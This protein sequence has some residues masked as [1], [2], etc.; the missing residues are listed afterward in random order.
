[1][2][3]ERSPQ[4]SDDIPFRVNWPGTEFSLVSAF[5][6]PVAVSLPPGTKGSAPSLGILRFPTPR[7]PPRTTS[8]GACLLPHS[9]TSFTLRSFI[10]TASVYRTQYVDVSSMLSIEDPAVTCSPTPF[11][12]VS[13][14]LLTN[15]LPVE[16][17][18]LEPRQVYSFYVLFGKSIAA[19][20]PPAAFS[21]SVLHTALPTHTHTQCVCVG[22]A[23]VSS[24]CHHIRSVSLAHYTYIYAQLFSLRSCF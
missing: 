12:N 22:R 6:N 18:S 21:P 7:P 19:L 8:A 10:H 14:G 20:P 1:M 9:K 3:A 13:L 4:L 11:L 23:D 16:E 24:L 2:A 5:A 17:V 15:A